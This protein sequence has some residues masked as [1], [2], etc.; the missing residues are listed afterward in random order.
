MRGSQYNFFASA[1]TFKYL[2]PFHCLSVATFSPK[3][4]HRLSRYS[5]GVE[6]Q[7]PSHLCPSPSFPLLSDQHPSAPGIISTCETSF[8]TL[9]RH[10]DEKE[11]HL[12]QIGTI[13]LRECRDQI[14][15]DKHFRAFV[16][17]RTWGQY[18]PES[19][20]LF[21]SI[22]DKFYLD[23][24][25]CDLVQGCGNILVHFAFGVSGGLCRQK[26]IERDIEV[27]LE[28]Y[29]NGKYSS[30]RFPEGTLLHKLL[31]YFDRAI[32]PKNAQ[33]TRV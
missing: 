26:A 32:L 31:L 16:V 6:T 23:G 24:T 33:E 17:N 13:L 3:L 30:S 20:S 25:M 8:F 4:L 9:D 12:H 2:S 29:Q 7:Q 5:K 15:D 19:G 1:G 28:S 21:P 14:R 27:W 22:E 10:G 18:H 11:Q